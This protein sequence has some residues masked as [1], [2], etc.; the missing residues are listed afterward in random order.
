M[1]I[2]IIAARGGSKRLPRKNV[3]LFCGRPLVAWSIIQTKTSYLI[4]EVFVTTD[5]DEI[6]S[7]ALAYGAKV[8]RRPDWSDA[9]QA[10]A[11]RPFLH[12]LQ[13]LKPLYPSMDTVLSILPTTP[14]NKPGDF[15]TAIT[16]Y[17][18]YGCD[19][20]GPA[21][22]SREMFV[23]RKL[24]FNRARTDL[25]DKKYNYLKEGPGYCVTSPEWYISYC[26]SL[27]TDLDKDLDTLLNDKDG[28]IQREGYYFPV[29]YWQYADVDTLEEFE[30]AEIIMERYILKGQDMK[31]YFDY[32]ENHKR[33][34][35][36][37]DISKYVGNSEQLQIKEDYN[38][39][40]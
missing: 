11:N 30:F 1:T 20:I 16:A 7:V 35:T 27:E 40:N 26:S 15:D 5:D 32:L 29:E 10:A 39:S 37:F 18:K 9:D 17:R 23:R 28:N 21:I 34:S 33:E 13:V 19:A 2:A 3:K 38:A 14:L 24:S 12:A 36:T 6:E 8:I 31:P 4:D 22:E 25:F